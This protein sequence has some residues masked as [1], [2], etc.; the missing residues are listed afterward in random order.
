MFL[1]NTPESTPASANSLAAPGITITR[2]PSTT[3]TR[4]STPDLQ[5]PSPAQGEYIFPTPPIS[6]PP[7]LFRLDIEEG[8]IDEDMDTDNDDS[9]QLLP[10]LDL[11]PLQ[12]LINHTTK[13]AATGSKVGIS[14]S[15]IQEFLLKQFL[16]QRN[17]SSTSDSA[18]GNISQGS[19]APPS[20]P[21]GDPDA[22]AAITLLEISATARAA[23]E[24]M[25]SDDSTSDSLASTYEKNTP[26]LTSASTDPRKKKIIIEKKQVPRWIPI[27]QHPGPGWTVNCPGTPYYHQFP[28]PD[29][30]HLFDASYI[31]ID[32]N[33]A[34]PLIQGTHGKDMPIHSRLLRA[35]R[36]IFK[37]VPPYSSNMIQ[38]FDSTQPFAF[39]VH[40]AIDQ[41]GDLSLTASIRHYMWQREQIKSLEEQTIT[42]MRQMESI[43]NNAIETLADLENADAFNRVTNA[44]SYLGNDGPIKTAE[45]HD[46]YNKI[47]RAEDPTFNYVGEVEEDR[48]DKRCHKCGIR[49]HIRA[50]CTYKKRPYSKRNRSAKNS[51]G[52]PW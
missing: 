27:G 24:T 51:K 28:I 14:A 9:D 26:S 52:L 39:A 42:L 40:N 18:D 23:A 10:A 13:E 38:L 48:M 45:A 3:A 35:K 2:P 16:H 41:E 5:F 17:K 25:T 11:P 50:N 49:G 46:A 15:I 34:Y 4:A 8:E 7:A 19:I 1:F 47:M 29:A 31:K 33:P 37:P 6:P 22:D 36:T 20:S 21:S 43:S 12:Q 44:M 32:L 30:G